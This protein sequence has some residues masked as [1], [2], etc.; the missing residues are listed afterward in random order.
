M[1]LP[2]GRIATGKLAQAIVHGAKVVQVDG[3]FDD[4]LELA[5]SL[6]EH[7]PSRWSTR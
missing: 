2:A 3:N 6:A 5:R 4:C 1:L 7:Y